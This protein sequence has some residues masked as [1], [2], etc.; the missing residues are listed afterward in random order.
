MAKIA[1]TQSRKLIDGHGREVNYLRISL[2][3]RC[4]LKCIYCHPP[5][6]IGYLD[7]A[8]ICS[9]GELYQVVKTAVRMGIDKVRLTGGEPLLRRG[10]LEFLRSLHELEHLRE[11]CLTTNGTLL[12]PIL[13]ELKEI[14]VKRINVSL[15]TLSE[16]LFYHMTG[17]RK[18]DAVMDAIQVASQLFK[19]KVNMVVLRGVNHSEI[20]RF[21]DTFLDKSVEVRF[22]E[23]MPL[24]GKGWKKDSFFPYEKIKEAF[25]RKKSISYRY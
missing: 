4:N 16:D 2:T 15:D 6:K 1:Q 13:N 5:Q 20:V 8:E 22:I 10:I 9:Y 23:F 17:S 18:L 3:D 14:G 7:R 25:L 12:L 21:M 11:V 24:C 19:V